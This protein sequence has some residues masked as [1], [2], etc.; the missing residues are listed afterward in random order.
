MNTE[1]T[2][3]ESAP[4]LART[5]EDT[6]QRRHQISLSSDMHQAVLTCTVGAGAPHTSAPP[7]LKFAIPLAKPVDP[8][9]PLGDVTPLAPVQVAYAA[10]PWGAIVGAAL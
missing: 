3:Q 9:P 1:K 8:E 5:A 10:C 7:I 2:Q 6:R 4:A